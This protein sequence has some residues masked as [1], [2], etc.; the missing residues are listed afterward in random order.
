MRKIIVL[1]S[2]IFLLDHSSSAQTWEFGASAGATGY[3]G[4]L[5]PVK[6]YKFNH[7][8]YGI[9]VKY[10]FN[11]YFGLKLNYLHG[12][13][14]ANDSLS[15]NAFQRARNIN[16]F[17]PVNEIGLQLEFNF[18]SYVPTL[19][20]KRFSPYLFAGIG[21]VLFDPQ[22]KLNGRVYDLPQYQTE[23]TSYSTAALSVP[24]GIGVKY[25]FS[26]KW[27]LAA[28][29]GY[30]TA[31]TDYLDDVSGVYPDR[32]A[33]SFRDPRTLLSDPSSHGGVVSPLFSPGDQRGDSRPHDTYMF[34]GISLIYTLVPFKCYRF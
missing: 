24:Y 18:F 5:N 6:P 16:F 25:N 30:R 20:K 15:N 7:P 14:S 13:I 10:N 29:I 34:T 9:L 27:T 21:A 31:Y 4:D 2:L 28:E 32:S 12:K 23:D 11:G 3:M 33:F 17:S 26:G 1:I 22:A 19:S 8:G